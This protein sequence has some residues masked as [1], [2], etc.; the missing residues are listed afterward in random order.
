[1]CIVA[2]KLARTFCFRRGRCACSSSDSA[3]PRR[4]TDNGCSASVPPSW[5]PPDNMP[6]VKSPSAGPLAL[7]L[8][9]LR[10]RLLAM[11]ETAALE[12]FSPGNFS[13]LLKTTISLCPECLAHVPALVF[14]RDGQALMRKRCDRHG[15]SE[16]LIE[17]D[18]TFYHLSNK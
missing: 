16:A 2:L 12:F 17:S 3:M 15:F 13:L 5:K 11:D 18:E 6:D 1:M 14:T 9:T 4:N 7:R 10:E 8:E